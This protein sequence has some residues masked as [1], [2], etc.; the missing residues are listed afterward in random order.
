LLSAEASSNTAVIGNNK[1]SD[2]LPVTETSSHKAA[3]V[4]QTTNKSKESYEA[5]MDF[6]A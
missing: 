5:A 1:E 6:V 2:D 4:D 3:V